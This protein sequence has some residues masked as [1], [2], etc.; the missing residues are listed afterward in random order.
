[1]QS[2]N[3]EMYPLIRAVYGSKVR[4][5]MHTRIKAGLMH[6][7]IIDNYLPRGPLVALPE[8]ELQEIK[9]VVSR[10]SPGSL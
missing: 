2:I 1:M 4:M 8:S 10:F 9:A 7:G 5:H 3:R 6:M